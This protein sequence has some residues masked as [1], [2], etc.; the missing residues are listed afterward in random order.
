MGITPFSQPGSK[1][2][3]QCSKANK[4]FR[5]AFFYKKFTEYT[6]KWHRVNMFLSARAGSWAMKKGP[7]AT[8]M[9]S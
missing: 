9:N 2:H 8:T 6:S 1:G 7:T 5:R 4:R 3:L